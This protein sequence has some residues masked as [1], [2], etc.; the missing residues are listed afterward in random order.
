V[1]ILTNREIFHRYQERREVRRLPAGRPVDAFWDL[2]TGD[3]VVHLTHGIGRFQQI[4][5]M[6]KRGRWQEFLVIEYREGVKLY[7][8]ASRIDLVQKY[9]GAKGIRPKLSLLG[10]QAWSR[11]KEEVAEAV[12]D[13]AAELL[14]MQ[15]IR[16]AQEGIR[17]PRDDEWQREFEASFPFPDTPDQAEGCEAIKSDMEALR[18]MDRLVCGDVGYGKTE[19]AVRAAFK[20][21][22]AGYQVVVLVP[23]TVLAEQHLR[24]FTE[25]MADYPVQ[26]E[27]L[28]RFRSRAQ[29]RSILERAARGEVD[30]LIG[31]HRVLSPDVVFRNLGLMIID[32]EQRFGVRHKETLKML[33]HTVDVLTLT[34]TPIPRTLH[35][36]LLGMRDIS[37]LAT[38]PRDR[39]SIQTRVTRYDDH[40]VREA[41]LREK[42]RGG[43]VFF[44]HNRVRSID[45]MAARLR[46]HVPEASFTVVHGQMGE[47]L[48]EERMV[49]FLAGEY[50]VLVTTTIIESGLDLPNVN[51]LIVNMADRFGLADLHQLRG[52]V[53]RYRNRAYA[54]FLLPQRGP[55]LPN[56]ERRLRAIE[57]FSE[58]GAGFQIAMRDL[59]IRGAG[60][61]LGP[62]QSGHIATVG[63]DLYCRLLGHAVAKRR[64]EPIL[65][66]PDVDILVDVDAYIP[67]AYIPHQGVRF[68]VYRRFAAVTSEGDLQEIRDELRDRFGAP[69]RPVEGLFLLAGLRL[70]AGAA[71]ISALV[72]QDDGLEIRHARSDSLEQL[73][74]R[75]PYRLAHLDDRT[76]LI[77]YAGE[78]LDSEDVCRHL[79]GALVDSP[80]G[81]R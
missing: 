46:R 22:T 36:S 63:Y 3:W 32:E 79:L 7:V 55:I 60:N 17:F 27:A 44:V 13:F 11:K 54:Y 62:Q 20:A 14:E 34:A 66:P 61:I 69:P 30:V 43:Q 59:E 56:A 45:K 74:R 72:R 1:S 4:V 37:S 9:V 70:A 26:T 8:P 67:E 52:R 28:S 50:D 35:M 31:T 57:E 10:G 77:P 80:S 18:P 48:L 58:L 65:E 5:R 75:L 78:D 21:A 29:Q 71:G 64:R 38:P 81:P 12:E 41:V 24:T 40:L 53:G 6:K 73:R 47:T 25:R 23:T 19:L 68:Q 16:N 39:L 15:A 33:R 2:K 49:S 76:A 51:T 42:A